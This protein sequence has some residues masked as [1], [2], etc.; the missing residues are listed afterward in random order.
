MA[1]PFF[2]ASTSTPTHLERSC[3]FAMQLACVYRAWNDTQNRCLKTRIQGMGILSRVRILRLV[4]D[5]GFLFWKQG[6]RNLDPECGSSL[7]TNTQA[8]HWRLSGSRRPTK[9]FNLHFPKKLQNSKKPAKAISDLN[10]A[11]RSVPLIS[12]LVPC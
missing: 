1:K 10:C 5:P 6:S 9:N 8:S 2:V 12:F 11:G 3:V 4:G 7:Q